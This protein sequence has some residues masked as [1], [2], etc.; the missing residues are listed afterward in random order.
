[1]TAISSMRLIA[2]SASAKRLAAGEPAR[3][4]RQHGPQRDRD[5]RR[6]GTDDEHRLPAPIR[7]GVNADQRTHRQADREHHL[8]RQR[9]A[10]AAL[11]L[12]KFVDIGGHQRDL[13]AEADALD[14]AQ[15]PHLV[16]GGGEGASEA[17]EREDQQRHDH[18][19]EPAPALGQPAEGDRADQL[20]GEPHGDER[21]DHLRD[22]RRVEMPD[23]DQR[24]QHI[25]DGDRIEGVEEPRAANDQPHVAMPGGVGHPFDPR[26]DLTHI[27]GTGCRGRICHEK[28]PPQSSS[29]TAFPSCVGNR[30]LPWTIS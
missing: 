26:H 29:F 5:Q 25:G 6:H 18:R 24:R 20:P 9:E 19:I 30:F 7:H 2:A 3:R 10:T 16:V 4:F 14:E 23:A 27:A 17:A 11:G 28:S 1:M 21:A 8:H 13:A 15:P 12:G 22:L